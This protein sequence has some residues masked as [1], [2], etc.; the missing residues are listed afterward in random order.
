[1]KKL[2]II[3]LVLLLGAVFVTAFGLSRPS[4]VYA[5]TCEGTGIEIPADIDP[6]DIQRYCS[7][8][9][10]SALTLTD[11]SGCDFG[12]SSFLGLPR[13]YKYLTGVVYIDEATGTK[14]CQPKMNGLVDIWKVVAAVVEILLRIASLLAVVF[15]MWGGVTYVTSQG[16]PDKTKQAQ[17]TVINA[18]I[19]LGISVAAT[20]FV[21]F[22][23]RKF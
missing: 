12:E 16:Q 15:V 18:L 7:D 23:A 1:M 4:R 5:E 11:V 2:K 21:T 22:I 10:A 17:S 14:Q 6:E 8:Q 13:W 20:A 3:S 19:G 9:E